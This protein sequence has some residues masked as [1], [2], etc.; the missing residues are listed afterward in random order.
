MRYRI[1]YAFFSIQGLIR[2]RHEDN[3]YAAG[4]TLPEGNS[5]MEGVMSGHISSGET[6]LFGVFDGMGGETAGDAASYLASATVEKMSPQNQRDYLEKLCREMNQAVCSYARDNRIR[7]M[8]TTA[9]C[10]LFTDRG[11]YCANVGDS[12]IYAADSQGF[13][14]ISE[15]HVAR[16]YLGK[17]PLTQYIGI[18][19]TEMIIQPSL[20][21]EAPVS[22]R[23][24]LICSDGVTDMLSEE[25]LK[26]IMS[27]KRTPEEKAERICG[28]VLE[29]GARDNATA[30]VCEVVKS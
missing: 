2:T 1:S 16:Y 14:K 4:F 10:V 5:G 28:R 22:G 23:Q 25:E 12:R 9:A 13:E 20:T 18:P 27:S 24:F 11:I 7:V 29:E 17:A 8:G 21:E 6:P 15:D 19:E 30:I 3:L 26:S